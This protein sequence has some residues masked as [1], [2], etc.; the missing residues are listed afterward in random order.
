V[1]NVGAAYISNAGNNNTAVTVDN[2]LYY[3]ASTSS[4]GPWADAHAKYADPLLVNAPADLHIRPGSP[5]KNAGAALDTAL[6][7]AL[8]I[9]GQSRVVDNSI[10]IGA[11]ELGVVVMALRSEGLG[12]ATLNGNGAATAFTL[13]G[14]ALSGIRAFSKLNMEK[15]GYAAQIIIGKIDVLGRTEIYKP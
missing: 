7:G 5:A 15:R 9:D 13:N 6:T 1:A 3:G 12:R 10:D 2:N 4:P 8:D 14:R 11:D